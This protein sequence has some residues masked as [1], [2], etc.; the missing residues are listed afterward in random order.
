M[1][2]WL[3]VAIFLGAGVLSGFVVLLSIRIARRWEYYDIPDQGR[4]LQAAPIPKLGGVAVAVAFCASVLIAL[5]LTSRTAELGLALTILV[6]ALGMALVGLLDDRR[7]L[8][9]YVRLLLQ[10]ALALL[11]WSMGTR[12][13]VADIPWVDAVIFVA[14]TVMIVNGINLLDNSDGLAAST[15]LVASIGA[16]IIARMFGQNLVWLLALAL[17]GVAV[18]FLAH[19]WAPARVYM[20]DAG[21]YFLGFL[22]AVLTVRLRPEQASPLEGVVI[23]VLLVLLPLVDTTYVV[24]Q[25]LRRGVHPFTAGRDHLSHVLQGVGLSVPK[26]VLALQGLMLISVAGAVAVAGLAR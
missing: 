20:G 22:L 17:A 15:V 1:T 3:G 21:A 6:P 24:V 26:S 14:W 25:R 4:K 18:G 10:S 9:P 19:N 16:A 8:N 13:V 7:G 23:A 12:L 11:A 5:I 2:T